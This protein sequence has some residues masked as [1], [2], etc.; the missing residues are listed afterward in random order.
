MLGVVLLQLDDWDEGDVGVVLDKEVV[1]L[2]DSV[3]E[4]SLIRSL[5]AL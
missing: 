5:L 1:H 4:I 2:I 3:T